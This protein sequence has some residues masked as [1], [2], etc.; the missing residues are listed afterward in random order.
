MQKLYTEDLIDF[1]LP[2]DRR[3]LPLN[4]IKEALV[5]SPDS[6]YQSVK[7]QYKGIGSVQ[8][9]SLITPNDLKY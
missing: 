1:Y 8:T 4:T 5:L 2:G 3:I 6:D 9:I 7:N